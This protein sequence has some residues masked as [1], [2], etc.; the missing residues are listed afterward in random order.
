MSIGFEH[1]TIDERNAVQMSQSPWISRVPGDV[2]FIKTHM[3]DTLMQ[4]DVLDDFRDHISK[5]ECFLYHG[6]LHNAREV[7][8]ELAV[9]DQVGTCAQIA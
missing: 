9:V 2:Q 7:E 6:L 4:W 3:I 8:L 1:L 5:T